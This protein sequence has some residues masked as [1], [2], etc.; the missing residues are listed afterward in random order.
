MWGRRLLF[1]AAVFGGRRR[2]CTARKQRR[3]KALH[4]FLGWHKGSE[5]GGKKSEEREEKKIISV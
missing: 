1:Q 2:Q 5:R 3:D 4:E